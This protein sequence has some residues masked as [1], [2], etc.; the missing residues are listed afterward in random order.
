M[1]NEPVKLLAKVVCLRICTH[2]A[3]FQPPLLER[4]WLRVA[5]QKP[6]YRRAAG[7]DLK[8]VVDLAEMAADGAVAQIQLAGNFLRA[9]AA[10]NVIEDF[11]LAGRQLIEAFPQPALGVEFPHHEAGD[12]GGH[13]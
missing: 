10:R 4:R 1:R 9:Q 13:R 8:F 6:G 7:V 2:E 3:A 12:R 5:L 11:Q